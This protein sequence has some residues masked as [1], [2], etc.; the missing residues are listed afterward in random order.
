MVIMSAQSVT[1]I[2]CGPTWATV[3]KGDSGYAGT[4]PKLAF[5]PT[6][7]QKAAGMRTLPAPSVPMDTGP[8]PA[9]TAAA[10][11]PEEPPGVRDGS[12][13]LRVIPVRGEFVSALHPNSGVVVL[14]NITAPASRSRATDGASSSHGW[15]GLTERLPRSVGHPL[16][17]WMS[18][19]VVGTPS[20][21]PTGD[22][23]ARCAAQ[24]ASLARAAAI[25]VSAS[26]KTKAL[27]TGSSR[28]TR[29]STCCS[30]S[31]GD[32]SPPP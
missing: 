27:S 18:L 19:I 9:A 26:T 1:L 28:S 6:L 8:R 17:Q 32:A 22:P 16:V 24:R 14:P 4:R 11:P 21:S 12:H 25:P 10:V 30:A 23:S 3:P 5:M 13:G 15:S 7:P 29:S 2:V 20:R 31:T